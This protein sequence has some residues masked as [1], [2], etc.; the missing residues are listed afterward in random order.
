VRGFNVRYR[1]RAKLRIT[2]LPERGL[3]LRP[4]LG[5]FPARFMDGYELTGH[6]LKRGCCASVRNALGCVLRLPCFYRVHTRSGQ[7]TGVQRLAARF[8]KRNFR[9]C[10]ES[11]LTRPAGN[12]VTETPGAT[13]FPLRIPA[14]AAHVQ[15][16]PLA[17][18]VPPERLCPTSA[19][20]LA[21]APNLAIR[22][23]SA[24]VQN[25]STNGEANR[26]GKARTQTNYRFAPKLPQR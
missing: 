22:K 2:V 1:Q 10:A 7:P 12:H 3:P 20:A 19:S 9:P 21:A 13:E 25:P 8:C 26:G 18:A 15:P 17:E 24:I 5:V 16:Q 6:L 4:V 23:P 11:H 14:A